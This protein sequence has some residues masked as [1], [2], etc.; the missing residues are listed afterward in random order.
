[1]A[2]FHVNQTIVSFFDDTEILITVRYL[3]SESMS[4][5]FL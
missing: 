1:M 2:C 4:V 3:I 5:D